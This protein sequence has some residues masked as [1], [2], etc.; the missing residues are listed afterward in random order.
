MTMWSNQTVF[1]ASSQPGSQGN[2]FM[3]FVPLI[4]IMFIFYFLIL[5]PQQR[6]QKQHAQMLE[7]LAKGDRVLTNGGLYATVRDVKDNL[8]VATIAEGVKVELSKG[9]VAAKV[10]GKNA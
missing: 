8:I 5:R 6:K 10:A 9:A 4:L 2:P 7:S 3:G 1:A